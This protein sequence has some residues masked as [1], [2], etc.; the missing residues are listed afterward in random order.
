M[1]DL[2]KPAPP[3]GDAELATTSPPPLA[4]SAPPPLPLRFTGTGGEYFRIWVVNLLLTLATLGIYSAWAKV[5]TARWF[6]GNT[7]LDGAAFEYHGKPGAI[8]RGRILAGALFVAYSLAGRLS[9]RAG[10]AAGAALLLLGPWLLHRA[11]RFKLSNT[12]WRGLRFGFAGSAGGA[13]AAIAPG[14]ALGALALGDLATLVPG[15]VPKGLLLAEGALFL[16]LPWLHARLKTWQQRGARY[17]TLA[18]DFEPS[19]GAFY[20][21]YGKA[22]LAA[23]PC[24]VVLVG[25]PSSS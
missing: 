4:P 9:V 23:A 1:T 3:A 22:G 20:K 6:W 14:L 17:G 16:L 24:L 19:T 8:L 15:E 25:G 2:Y 21:L 13:Y 11:V 12:S 10:A 5:R 7:Q 18:F